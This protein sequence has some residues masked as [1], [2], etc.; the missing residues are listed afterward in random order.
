MSL[1]IWS[2]QRRGGRPLGRRHDEGV[3]YSMSMAWVPGCRR[4]NMYPKAPRRSLR[5]VVVRG[6]CPVRIRIEAFVTQSYQRTPTMR[7]RAFVLNA[8]RRFL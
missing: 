6:G 2:A 8:S 5:I 3:V 1:T 7:R 4:H